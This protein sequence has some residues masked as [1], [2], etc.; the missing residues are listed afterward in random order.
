MPVEAEFDKDMTRM[1]GLFEQVK[2]EYDLYF[3][4]TRKEPPTKEFRD[5]DR[6]VKR[7]ANASLPR[8]AQQ[9]RFS[10]FYSKF[11]LYSEQW[12]KWLRA[13]EEGFTGDPRISGAVRRA[14]KAYSRLD[15]GAKEAERPKEAATAQAVAPTPQEEELLEIQVQSNEGRALR[16]LFDDFVSASLEAGQV[17]QWDFGSF[18]RHLS[19]QRS[20]ILQK[21]KGKDVQFAVQT[22]DGKVSLKAKVVK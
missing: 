22:K 21:Y 6:L 12:M 8:L 11:S 17:P 18:Q 2:H 20:A 7:Y 5:L 3:A 13:K 16:R 1:L 10:S 14:K 4:G 15:S 9:F 19:S